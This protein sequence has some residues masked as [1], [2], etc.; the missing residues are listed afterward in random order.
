MQVTNKRDF[1]YCFQNFSVLK[2]IQYTR[3]IVENKPWLW[4]EVKG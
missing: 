1:I 2:D 4:T 3:N